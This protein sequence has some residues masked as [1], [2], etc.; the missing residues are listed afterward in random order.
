MCF[1][2]S[3][4]TSHCLMMLTESVLI[5][6]GCSSAQATRDWKHSS[7]C[8][9]QN[10]RQPQHE[11]PGQFSHLEAPHMHKENKASYKWCFCH[12]PP[13]THRIL[14]KLDINFKYKEQ[15]L[16]W[17]L[18]PSNFRM[19][20]RLNMNM[21]GHAITAVID[22][23]ILW[24]VCRRKWRNWQRK[25]WIAW[26]V[27]LSWTRSNLLRNSRATSWKLR[28][29]QHSRYSNTVIGPIYTWY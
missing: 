20:I 16:C 7:V 18:Y 17:L 21:E 23:Y 26:A 9:S 6:R 12:M 10:K 15:R 27:A 29:R 22:L 3:C 8:S 24:F 5:H 25:V 1:H 11:Q 14:L 4:L 13:S 2:L 28:Q 19:Y